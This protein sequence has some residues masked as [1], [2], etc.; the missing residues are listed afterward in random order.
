MDKFTLHVLLETCTN[1]I[2]YLFQQNN[3]INVCYQ[4][5]YYHV[6]LGAARPTTTRRVL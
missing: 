4:C 3:F 1:K 6:L 5:D 2:F